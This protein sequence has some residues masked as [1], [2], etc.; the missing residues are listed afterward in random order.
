M[1]VS[2][3]PTRYTCRP[4]TLHLYWSDGTSVYDRVS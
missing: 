2:A 4:S 3:T 1:S